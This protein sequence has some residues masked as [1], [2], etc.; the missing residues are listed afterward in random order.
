LYLTWEPSLD[1]DYRCVIAKG[2]TIGFVAEKIFIFGCQKT[3]E[4]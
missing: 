3:I 4:K 1:T 2:H